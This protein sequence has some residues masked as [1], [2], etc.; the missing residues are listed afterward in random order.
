MS[1]VIYFLVS[2]WIILK[3]FPKSYLWR[4]FCTVSAF[5][6]TVIIAWQGKVIYE[7]WIHDCVTILK[8]GWSLLEI[9]KLCVVKTLI[10]NT[11]MTSQIWINFIG[12][13]EIWLKSPNAFSLVKSVGGW[14]QD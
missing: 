14:G 12:E 13:P 9:S 1:P 2:D 7:A 4:G 8:Y 6:N 3:L 11:I 10:Q 5:I